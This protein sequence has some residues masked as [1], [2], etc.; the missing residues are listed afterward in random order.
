MRQNMTFLASCLFNAKKSMNELFEKS[1]PPVYQALVAYGGIII[2]SLMVKLG[3]LIGIVS[4]SF[5]TIWILTTAILLLFGIFNSLF[6][7]AAPSIGHYWSRSIFSYAGL[8]I[9]SALT[10]WL[11][12]SVSIGDAATFKWLFLVVTV[13]YLVFL[14]VVGFIRIIIEIARRKDTRDFSNRRYKK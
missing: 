11:F 7:L 10:A 6:C 14:S 8:A 4:P 13:G 2:L 5:M 1:V 3:Q 12:T 9:M